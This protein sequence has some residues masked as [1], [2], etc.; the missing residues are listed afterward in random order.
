MKTLL[1]SFSKN[2]Q[3][4][5]IATCFVVF[6]YAVR[7]YFEPTDQRQALLANFDHSNYTAMLFYA[8]QF[9]QKSTKSN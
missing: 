1:E 6:S 2:S 9:Q 8:L 4:V 7:I 5:L 3:A